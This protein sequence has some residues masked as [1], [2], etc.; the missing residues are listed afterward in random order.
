LEDFHD[1]ANGGRKDT[2]LQ[3]SE[4]F[5]KRI[6]KRKTSRKTKRAHKVG[7]ADR[8]ILKRQREE[9]RAYLNKFGTLKIKCPEE[10]ACK[11]NGSKS[12]SIACVTEKLCK[13]ID[14]G[15]TKTQKKKHRLKDIEVGVFPRGPHRC[16][17]WE[18]SAK[19]TRFDK[20][21]SKVTSQLRK[22][23]GA[24]SLRDRVNKGFIYV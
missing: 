12:D 6:K 19:V 22:K 1:Y 14:I 5:A 23:C 8:A 7:A 10:G 17:R 15:R 3:Y 2:A 20:R 24:S 11:A 13:N 4:G 16:D 18:P 9:Q 21:V